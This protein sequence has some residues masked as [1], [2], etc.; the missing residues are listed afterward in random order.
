M[1]QL[2]GAILDTHIYIAIVPK[3]LYKKLFVL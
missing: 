3:M 1:V 2:I